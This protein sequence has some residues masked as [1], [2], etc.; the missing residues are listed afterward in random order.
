MSGGAVLRKWCYLT[1]AVTEI[2]LC[3]G[4]HN[5]KKTETIEIVTVT[6]L[7]LLRKDYRIRERV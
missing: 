7:G 3:G 2:E 6:G 4:N 5:N 1:T